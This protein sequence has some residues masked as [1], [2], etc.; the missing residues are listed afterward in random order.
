MNKDQIDDSK[1]AAIYHLIVKDYETSNGGT[2]AIIAC[3]R[4][5]LTTL[6][7]LRKVQDEPRQSE[8]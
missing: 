7:G 3:I 5:M 6:E 8:Q 1:V 4:H 2:A